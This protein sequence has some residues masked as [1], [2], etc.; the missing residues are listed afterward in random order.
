MQKCEQFHAPCVRTTVYRDRTG[1]R[2]YEFAAIRGVIIGASLNKEPLNNLSDK[3]PAAAAQLKGK[4]SV[5]F[6]GAH[7]FRVW[8]RPNIKPAME[9]WFLKCVGMRKIDGGGA[10]SQMEGLLSFIVRE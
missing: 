8:R 3:L 9:S 4:K 5:V 1:W 10:R 6:S 7:T 2:D